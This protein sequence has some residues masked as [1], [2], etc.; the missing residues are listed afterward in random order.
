MT[1]DIQSNLSELQALLKQ[2][3]ATTY[4]ASFEELSNAT[5]GQHIRHIIEL[6][7]CMINGYDAALIDYD[8]RKRDRTLEENPE[9]A[10][11]AI[12][13]IILKVAKEDK[14]MKVSYILHNNTKS[15]LYSSYYREL[16]YNLEHSI[17]HQAII[18]GVLKNLPNIQLHENFGVAPSTISYRMNRHQ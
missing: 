2:I 14:A 13:A 18:K 17:H 10:L 15:E 7:Q 8:N 5:I 16:L 4:S 11:K 6:F 9:A 3:D 1:E 12:D